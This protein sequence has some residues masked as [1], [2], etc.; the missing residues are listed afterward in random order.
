MVNNDPLDKLEKLN[1]LLVRDLNK[2]L[3]NTDSFQ[4]VVNYIKNETK[5]LFMSNNDKNN[6]LNKNDSLQIKRSQQIVLQTV[7]TLLSE[8]QTWSSLD[9]LN[10]SKT[11]TSLLDTI[12]VSLFNSTNTLNQSIFINTSLII[13]EFKINNHLESELKFPSNNYN[14]QKNNQHHHHYH[15]NDN[16]H[17]KDGVVLKLKNPSNF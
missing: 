2:T 7:N 11:A 8:N 5:E 3:I 1:K 14:I 13:S 17:Q 9:S 10:R 12:E 6:F 4:K 16:I 15:N